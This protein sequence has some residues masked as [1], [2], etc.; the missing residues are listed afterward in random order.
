MHGLALIGVLVVANLTKYAAFRFGPHYAAATGTS[1]LEGYRKRGR[2]ALW[3]Y[4]G[5]TV[6]TMF[7]VQAA[8]TVV[9]AAL[10]MVTLGIK[11]NPIVVSACLMLLCA[12]LLA[13]G[14]YRW[15]DRL[16]KV[17]VAVFTL[18]TLV[19]T[20][21]VLPKVTWAQSPIMGLQ[22]LHARAADGS[23]PTVLFVA[24]FMGWMPSAVDVAVWQSL[25]TLAR[26]GD[27][28]HKPTLRESMVDFH[29][30]Y[31]G[32]AFLALCFLLLGAGV[33]HQSGATFPAPAGAFAAQFIN[34]Y[35]Q[36]LGEWSRPV[37]GVAAFF[38]MFSTTLTVVDGFPRALSVLSQRFSSEEE[39]DSE[40]A[41]T[42]AGRRKAYWVSLGVLFI[43]S[44]LVLVFLLKS[45]KT[46]V[47]IATTLSFLTAP[48]L[49]A[50]NHRAVTGA[51]VPAAAR[52]KPWL[53]WLSRLSILFLTLFAL[54]YLFFR[55]L[56]AH[57]L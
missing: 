18:A 25:W 33:M 3:L 6:A 7:T 2:A 36:T 13:V 37:I 12:I 27:T 52:P 42:A 46:L 23:F 55:Y 44:M 48:I 24:A 15:L 57:V 5:V 20:I 39:P 16:V 47:D 38:V 43:G 17:L 29:I 28:G 40:S 14:H 53:L 31:L 19:A 51:E 11:A 35:A 45:L 10:G 50:L 54:Y 49:A 1:L 26:Q 21:V 56:A 8:V 22:T 30:G 4:S 9:T 34:L 32:T 41:E